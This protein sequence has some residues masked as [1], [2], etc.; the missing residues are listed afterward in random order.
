MIRSGPG[1][2]PESVPLPGLPGWVQQVVQSGDR[3]QSFHLRPPLGW[4]SLAETRLAQGLGCIPCC[5]LAWFSTI[6]KA[7]ALLSLLPHNSP[8]V[9]ILLSGYSTRQGPHTGAREGKVCVVLLF[10]PG[11]CF[12]QQEWSCPRLL[13]SCSRFPTPPPLLCAGLKD[14]EASCPPECADGTC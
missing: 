12:C 11:D 10:P 2:L 7:L 3:K 13:H 8:A 5:V 9:L 6:T 14:S 4:Q 1:T